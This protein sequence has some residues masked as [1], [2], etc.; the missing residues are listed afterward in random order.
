MKSQV[1][2]PSLL[3]AAIVASLSSAHADSLKYVGMDLGSNAETA[4]VYMNGNKIGQTDIGKIS[5]HDSTDHTNV[6][7][8]CADVTSELN[9]S[10][11]HY[12]PSST[13]P[14]GSTPI[15]AAGRIVGT[16]FASAVTADQQAGLQ[17]AVWDTLYNGSSTFNLTNHKSGSGFSVVGA[18]AGAMTWA[19]TYFGAASGSTGSALYFKTSDCGGQSQLTAQAVPEPSMFIGLGIASLGLIRR[20]KRS[21]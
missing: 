13:N 9:G 12:T 1:I 11:H 14:L 17:L 10:S 21:K 16:Y 18:S 5:F 2:I 7:T 6:A 15:D 3:A 8:V 19:Q 20:F 4:T